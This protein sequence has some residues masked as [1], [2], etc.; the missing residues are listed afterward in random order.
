MN[1]CDYSA[2]RTD[3]EL[4]AGW[5]AGDAKA[6]EA[7]WDRH[8]RSVLRFFRNKVPWPVATDLAQRTIEHGLR[9]RQ[10]VV[11]FR[12]YLLGIARHQ[13]LDH[14]RAE[15]R[16]RRRDGE[17]AQL[18]IEDAVGSPEDWM[19]AKRERR[20]LLRALRRLPL[21]LQTVLELRYWEQLSGPEI[22]EVMEVPLGTVK[23]RILAGRSA[24]RRLIEEL[25]GSPHELRSTLDSL[26]GWAARVQAGQ[27]RADAVAAR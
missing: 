10:P 6:G 8:S 16:K 25:A 24:L 11:S 4:L 9:L 21:G 20:L 15:Q 13:L 5:W 23:S 7:L 14:L 22:A 19:V 17:L 18:A 27:G 26:E 12:C 3:D 1:I 2:T